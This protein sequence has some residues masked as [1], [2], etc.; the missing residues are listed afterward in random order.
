MAAAVGLVTERVLLRRIRGQELPEVLVTVGVALVVT[1]LC[2]AVFGGNPRSIQPPAPVSGAFDL[3]PVTYPAYRL[4]LIGL[5]VIVGVG[6]Y[7]VQHHSR[8]G[9]L[10]RAGVDD[11]EMA[12]AMGIDIDRL[13]AIMFVVGAGLAGL[14]GVAAAGRPDDPA[15]GRHGHPPVRA[16]RRDRRRARQRRR[17]SGRQRPHRGPR[18]VREG[19]DPRALLL[20]GIP[21]DGDRPRPPASW[22][23]RPSGVSRART[24]RIAALGVAGA[25]VVLAPLVLSSYL[26]T[27][28]TLVF[29]AGLL[30]AS[31]NYL[32]GEAGLVSMGQAGIA[33]AAAYGVAWATVRGHDVVVQVGLA[34][35]VSVVV[36][37]IY[38]VTTMRSRGIVFLMITLALGMIVFGLAFK[39]ASITGG[40]NGLTGIDRPA[41]IAEPWRFY[42]VCAAAFVVGTLILRHVARS[43]VRPRGPR[44]SRER[45]P[46]E[47]PRLSGRRRSS[48]A[49]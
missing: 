8:L 48:S 7:L 9:A 17:G 4:F 22:A 24:W 28:L 38:A 14:A 19:L 12:S 35:V 40:Q 44:R 45:E 46:D 6:L 29:I 15:R 13:F 30:A 18:R 47:Q 3:G 27:L 31:V 5:A 25:A 23:A 49:R 20:R 21:A 10:I 34:L 43:P 16:R 32:A 2:L 33:A 26:L 39:L 42:L 37:A 11:R 1:D 41:L 36:S